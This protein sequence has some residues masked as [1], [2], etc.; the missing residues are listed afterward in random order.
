MIA[1]W[2]LQQIIKN[3]PLSFLINKVLKGF[4]KSLLTE[5][6]PIDT[7]KA[8]DTTDYKILS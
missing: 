5:M 8:F 2:Y 6:I 3:M 7:Q 1:N 4:D